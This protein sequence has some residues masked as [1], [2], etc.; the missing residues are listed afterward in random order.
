MASGAG[1]E[2]ALKIGQADLIGL[3]RVLRA[4]PEWPQKVPTG[5]EADILHCD[6]DCGDACIQ[7]VMKGRSAY[8]VQWPPD[9][10][11]AWKTKFA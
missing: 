11:K 4:D 2:N 1:A 7:T 5:R 10:I 8:C 9:K 6:P 3:A